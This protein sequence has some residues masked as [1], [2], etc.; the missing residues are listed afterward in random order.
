MHLKDTKTYVREGENLLNRFREEYAHEFGF[1]HSVQES[2][3]KIDVIKYLLDR[4]DKE[5]DKDKKEEKQ[6]KY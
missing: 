5:I 1:H 6:R 2:D 4:K 3:A